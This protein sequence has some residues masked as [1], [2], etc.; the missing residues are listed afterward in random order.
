M[1][2]SIPLPDLFI[3]AYTIHRR[4]HDGFMRYKGELMYCQVA[5]DH[6]KMFYLSDPADPFHNNKV[7]NVSWQPKDMNID[8]LPL[9]YCRVSNADAVYITRLPLRKQ[10]QLTS[11][12]HMMF[13]RW[14]DFKQFGMM[15]R[16]WLHTQY[17]VECVENKHPS[18][19]E[20]LKWCRSHTHRLIPIHRHF[21]LARSQDAKIHL[22]YKNIPIGFLEDEH[23]KL[24]GNYSNC[25]SIHYL[26]NKLSIPVAL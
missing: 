24:D 1:D 13:N 2:T 25:T 12:E 16:E 21:A 26:A 23:F 11:H 14:P 9:G 18:Y 10:K 20:A 4:M 8:P 17:F 15:P 19:Q 22:L 5:Q 7:I 6:R 3:D